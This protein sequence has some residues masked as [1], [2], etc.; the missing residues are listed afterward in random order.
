MTK[1]CF[2][3][4]KLLAVASFLIVSLSLSAQGVVFTKGSFEEIISLAKKEGKNIFVDAYTT[5]CVPCKK[6]ATQTFP[7]S[8]VGDFFNKN[9]VSIKLDAE[10]ESTH[11]FFS[12]YKA[13]AFPTFFWLNSDG[14]LMDKQVGY[15]EPDKLLE[16]TKSALTKNI[17]ANYRALEKRWENGERSNSLFMEYVFGAMRTIAPDKIK[18][19]TVDYLNSL[20]E[21]QLKSHDTYLIVR[22]FMREPAHDVIFTTLLKNWDN[23]LAQEEDKE[24]MWVNMYRSLVRSTSANL[25]NGDIDKYNKALQEIEKLDFKYKTF[26][27]ESLSLESLI[28]NRSYDKAL[29]GILSM[30]DKYFVQHPYIYNQYLYTL[31]IG[32]FFVRNEIPATEAEKVLSIAKRNAKSKPTQESMLF[33]AASYAAKGDYKTAYE[34]LASLG[35]YP[36][37]ML[38]NAVYSK[39]KLPVPRDEYPWN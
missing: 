17:E 33:L 20:N 25:L 15:M 19:Y 6:M 23:Y 21:D 39:L 38:S 11:G 27:L 37:P 29:D 31:V 2:R 36:K 24:S 9:F 32:G 5:W 1:N 22:S 16:V 26:Y 34:Y 13:D 4:Y 8:K 7:D 28:F 10:N 14:E 3:T 12:K 35:F 30:G 18:Q